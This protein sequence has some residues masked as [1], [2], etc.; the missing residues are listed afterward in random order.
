MWNTASVRPFEGAAIGAGERSA[1]IELRRA[2]AMILAAALTLIGLGLVMIYNTSGVLSGRFGSPTFFL[3]KQAAWA[4]VSLVVMFIARGIDYHLLVRLRKPILLA[5]FGLLL[6]VLI[7]GLG[8]KLNGARRWFRFAGIGFQPS[9]IAK[10]G[11]IVY[12]AGFLGQKQDVLGSWKRGF[13]PLAVVVGAAVGLIAV[14]PDIGTAALLACTCVAMLLVGGVRLRHL[15]P[16]GLATVPVAAG[17]VV[18]KFPHVRHRLFSFIDPSADPLGTGYHARQSLIALAGG[19]V[20]GRGLTAGSQKLFF[21]PEAHTDFIF[22]I[23]GEELGLVGALFVMGAFAA[24]LIGAMTIIRFAPDRTG[25]LITTGVAVWLG[26][27]AAFNV[28]VVTASVPTKGIPLPFVS[29]GGST[30]VV[31]AAAIGIVLNVAGHGMTP[32]R[33]GFVGEWT[34]SVQ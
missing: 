15:V 30:L 1:T 11:M 23:I 28:A 29:Y 19:G 7:P 12:L 18:L 25:A 27:Q 21:L 8:V 32:P 10:I 14:E 17:F 2:E 22:S 20:F 24:I 3:V 9:D 4:G 5:I 33:R 31:T 16:A 34:G 6:A 13:I 26:L